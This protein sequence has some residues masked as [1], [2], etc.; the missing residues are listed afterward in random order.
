MT[1]RPL[2]VLITGPA[3][4]DE[5]GVANYYGAVLRT[6]RADARLEVE[7]LE[8][9]S[10][11]A[12]AGPLH[13]L[14]DQLRFRAAVRRFRPD[15]VHV[16]PSL[17]LKSLGRDALLVDHARRRGIPVLVFFRGWDPGAEARVDGPLRAPFRW[18]FGR[19]NGFA[20]LAAS[21]RDKLRAWGVT[22][23]IAL[24]TTT[25]SDG[26]LEGFSIAA[27]AAAIRE[28]PVLRILFLARL[29]RDKGV[30]DTLEAAR[31]LLLRGASVSLTIAGDGPAMADVRSAVARTNS[32]DRIAL[33]GY[34]RGDAKR[35]LLRGHHVYCFPSGYGEGMPNSVLE[36]MALGMPVVTCA[37][38][39]LADFF[40][41]GRM[42]YLVPPRDAARVA[43]ALARLSGDREQAAAMAEYNHRYAVRR[44]LSPDVAR[45]L[46]DLYVRT[47]DEARPGLVP[48]I[49]KA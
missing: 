23:P 49:S 40:E 48:G 13:P 47:A 32:G 21:F 17:N 4:R 9:G 37:V 29:E 19:A 24:E 26:T 25:V 15:V 22:A 5:G 44:F 6:L 2:R 34:V 8:L 46:A 27:K 30:L 36:A 14:A 18:T 11:A 16:N 35:E 45:R 41:D 10:T 38:G 42:G 33:A 20:V 28:E 7:Y 1:A 3:L 43:E 39:G 31:T 12:A